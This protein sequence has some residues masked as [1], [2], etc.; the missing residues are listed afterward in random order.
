[1]VSDKNIKILQSGNIYILY[2]ASLI[3]N[4]QQQLFSSDILTGDNRRADSVTAIGRAPV[5]FFQ[6]KNLHLVLRHYYRG[7]LV[8]KLVRDSYFGRKPEKTRA[9]QEWCLLRT[10]RNLGLPVP[11]PVAARIIT[12][13]FLYQAD[14]VT[15]QI[16]NSRTLAD[17][18]LS[19]PASVT[20]WQQ[21]GRC[22]REFHTHNICHADLNARN[23][24]LQKNGLS[25]DLVVY[26]IDFDRGTIKKCGSS[27]QQLNLNRLKRSLNKFKQHNIGF[28]F[29]E[30]NWES[31]LQGYNA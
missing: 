7:G 13:G 27:W 26:L 20:L 31:L 9:F 8:A 5:I 22:I 2:D 24:L 3:E 16:Q 1:M 21:M 10:M 30:A 29:N 25:D 18:L 15:L 19:H 11:L 14:L 23:I 6:S 28:Y 4:P 12:K 17:F